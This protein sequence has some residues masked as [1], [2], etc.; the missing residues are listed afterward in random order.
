VPCYFRYNPIPSVGNIH[1]SCSDTNASFQFNYSCNIYI[2]GI[3]IIIIIIIIALVE[4]K[5]TKTFR[6]FFIRQLEKHVSTKGERKKIGE[7]N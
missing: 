4:S 6:S 7:E 1:T 2:N 3:I 5:T